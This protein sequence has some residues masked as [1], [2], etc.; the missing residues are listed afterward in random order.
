M[1]VVQVVVAVGIVLATML[2]A[3][4]RGDGLSPADVRLGRAPLPTDRELGVADLSAVRLG[5]GLRGYRMD[6]VDE[7]LER[8]ALE[9]GRRD[10]RIAELE[11]LRTLAAARPQTDRTRVDE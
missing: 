10:E 1:F 5:V 4:G 2:V 9:V 8:V 11:R 3:G 6:E 7:L